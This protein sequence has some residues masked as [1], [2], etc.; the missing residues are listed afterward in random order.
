KKQEVNEEINKPKKLNE[1]QA[2]T[3]MKIT[4]K[5]KDKVKYEINRK[6]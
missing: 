5:K 6:G 2:I 4:L 1:S 3:T